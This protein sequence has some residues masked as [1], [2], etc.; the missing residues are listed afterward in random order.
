MR[1]SSRPHSPAS[2][3]PT[4]LDRRKQKTRDAVIA[5]AMRLFR[6]RG[7]D[8]VTMEEI[9]EAADVAKGTLYSHFPVKDA[10]VAAFVDRESIARNA[11]R[12]ERMRRLPDTRARLTASLTEL[13]A[14]VRAQP[15][16]FEKYFTYRTKQMVSLRRDAQAP[17]GL[18]YLEDEIIRMGQDAGELR[19]DLPLPLLEALFEFCFIIVAQRYFEAPEHFDAKRTI[20]QCVDVF[21]NGVG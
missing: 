6:D 7:F 2:P 13:A 16:L 19:T 14:A 3:A 18:R 17:A 15:E 4:R 8:A 21:M 11:E 9:A 12:V 5:A 1:T 10:I 20:R